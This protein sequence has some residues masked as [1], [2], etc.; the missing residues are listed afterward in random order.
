MKVACHRGE[1][2]IATN[3]LARGEIE[4]LHWRCGGLV[5]LFFFLRQILS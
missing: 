1:V 4:C 2:G 5:P 3:D